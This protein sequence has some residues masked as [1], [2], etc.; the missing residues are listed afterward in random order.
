MKN[1]II[2]ISKWNVITNFFLIK[3]Y[4]DGVIVKAGNRTKDELVV[5][6]RFFRYMEKLAKYDIPIGAYFAT[7][8]I[9]EDEAIEEANFFVDAVEKSGVKLSIPLFVNVDYVSMTKTGRSDSLSIED[10]TNIIKAFIKQCNSKGY[11]CGLYTKSS[12]IDKN[13]TYF[14]F[15]DCPI[16]LD[17]NNFIDVIKNL[18]IFKSSSKY[19]VK[20]I[21]GFVSLNE[22]TIDVSEFKTEYDQ[23]EVVIEE[24]VAE[25]PEVVEEEVVEEP[26]VE[27]T[28]ETEEIPV[29]V[30][31]EP[32][33]IEEPVE[34]Q[35][36]APVEEVVEEKP[37]K[38]KTEKKP[39]TYQT[40]DSIKVRGRELY[41]SSVSSTILRKLS[42]T[43]YI[44]NERVLN[45]RIRVSESKDGDSIGWITL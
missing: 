35:E 36:E 30:V 3:D 18:F 40:G 28:I 45:N 8:A 24:P 42:G 15:K 34:I 39:K 33:V 22:S 12:W 32:E 5:D 37:A 29:E 27:E 44:A 10:R 20:G 2:D 43:F 23:E 11:V 7:A 25:E 1:K 41:K 14:E 26:V 6:S 38:K 9:T 31:E 19:E 16:W 21:A 13:I 4:T 17:N